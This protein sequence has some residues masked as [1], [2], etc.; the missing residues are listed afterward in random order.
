[1]VTRNKFILMIKSISYTTAISDSKTIKEF[2]YA[3]FIS[4]EAIDPIIK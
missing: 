1:M 3:A 2:S 4:N